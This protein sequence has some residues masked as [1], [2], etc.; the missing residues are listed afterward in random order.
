LAQDTAA[1]F[2]GAIITDDDSRRVVYEFSYDGPANFFE[3][4]EQYYGWGSFLSG[5]TIATII[6]Y[7]VTSSDSG[8]L[9]VDLI[10]AGGNRD[11]DGKEKDPH[12]IQ[13]VV[14][15]L[16]EGGLAIG[17]MR[18][19]GTDATAALSAMSVAVGLPFTV[20][21]CF[22][23]PSLYRMLQ[24]DDGEIKADDFQW[25]MPIYGG[26]L[27]IMDFI[28]SFGG[29]LGGAPSVGDLVASFNEFATGFLP[30]IHANK[31]L[32]K[33]D[34]EG[35]STKTN[36]LTV[37]VLFGL[38]VLWIV[39]LSI[40]HHSSRGGWYAFA[41][42]VYVI[43]ALILTQI[44]TQV[45]EAQGINGSMVEDFMCCFLFYFNTGPQNWAQVQL[46]AKNAPAPL[47]E[48][49]EKKVTGI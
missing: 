14:W 27:D 11:K 26:F 44:R 15:S 30:F 46:P 7:F 13:R 3:I 35:K 48:V 1:F 21:L 28:F 43:M 31:V 18:S 36:K 2:A 16:T 19:G 41:S 10:S 24:I 37:F 22:M 38:W 42:T 5:V 40:E 29:M 32:S 4:L 9:V 39:S 49:A 25:A 8:S 33:I 20:V 47:N 12:W 6:L 23:M 17:L 34:P 45:R